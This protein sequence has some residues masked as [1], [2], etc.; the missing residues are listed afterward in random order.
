MAEASLLAAYRGIVCDLDGVV[1]RGPAAVEGAVEALNALPVP[2]VYATNNASRPPVEV[3]AHLADL[4]V[5]TT[6]DRVVNSSMAGAAE[7]A[8]SAEPGARVLAVGGVGVQE[9]LVSQGFQAVTSAAEPVVAVLQGYGP[10]VT[11]ADLAEAAYAIQ[12]GA[13]WV[14]TNTDLTLPTDR[15]IAPGNGSL[16]HCVSLATGKQPFVVGKPEAPLYLMSSAV[17]DLDPAT[18]LGVGDRLETDIAG[19]SAAG[20]DGA[21]VLTGVHGA[22]AA[23]LA[24]LP[25]RPRY[26]I[27]ALADLMQPYAAAQAA[28]GGFRCGAAELRIDGDRLVVAGDGN[29]VEVIRAGLAAIWSAIDGGLS[30]E[31]AARLAGQL[32]DRA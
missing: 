28:D 4:G 6:A 3:A 9:A 18:V 23:A 8:A 27:A 22:H 13:R 19:A 25:E 11:A 31:E 5:R 20:M 21:L 16:V 7:L 29:P 17:L 2:V 24:P 15:G 26:V 12:A 32:P 14:A 10:Q 30:A 1:Y